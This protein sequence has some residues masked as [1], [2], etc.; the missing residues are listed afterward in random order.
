MFKELIDAQIHKHVSR[1]EF[2]ELI[3][4]QNYKH[5]S[6]STFQLKVTQNHKHSPS[7]Q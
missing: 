1:A 3:D 5:L 7:G 4:A 2:E 6:R